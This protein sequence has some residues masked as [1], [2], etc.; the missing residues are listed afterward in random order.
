MEEISGNIQG[1]FKDF[2][3]GTPVILLEGFQGYFWKKDPKENPGRIPGESLE[4]LKSKISMK[5][6]DC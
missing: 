1:I 2:L 3:G 5:Y 4:P 6:V